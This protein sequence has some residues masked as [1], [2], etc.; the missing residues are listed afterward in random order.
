MDL[1]RDWTERH[2]SQNEFCNTHFWLHHLDSY[3]KLFT[4]RDYSLYDL[5]CNDSFFT[6]SLLK[7]DAYKNLTINQQ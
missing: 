1:S 5:K 4:K 3:F 2:A 7:K 6:H